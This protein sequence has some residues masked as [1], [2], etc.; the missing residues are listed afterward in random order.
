MYPLEMTDI[1]KGGLSWICSKLG[2]SE[3]RPT[4]PNLEGNPA[5]ITSSDLG[6]RRLML[7]VRGM[8]AGVRGE[9]MRALAL[10]GTCS[11]A[12]F[13]PAP[14]PDFDMPHQEVRNSDVEMDLLFFK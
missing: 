10:Q 12:M 9:G 1:D 14:S 5:S 8:C 3:P 4:T 7:A 13:I 6:K 2:L 11:L